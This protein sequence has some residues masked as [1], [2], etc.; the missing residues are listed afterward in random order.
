[1]E[2]GGCD[3]YGDCSVGH[4]QL[5]TYLDWPKTELFTWSL[6]QQLIRCLQSDRAVL[7]RAKSPL[8]SAAQTLR[9]TYGNL[10]TND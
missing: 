5:C 6:G 4:L 10:A 2:I 7:N 1:M 3:S 8:N 9:S